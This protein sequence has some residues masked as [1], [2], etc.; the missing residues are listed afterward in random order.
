MQDLLTRQGM[1]PDH[2]AVYPARRFGSAGQ[3]HFTVRDL[4]ARVTV[5]D[6]ALA[7]MALHHGIGR[8]R[9]YGLGMLIQLTPNHLETVTS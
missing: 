5:T 3:I 4:T 7:P 9:A 8:G 6:A 1:P 2:P